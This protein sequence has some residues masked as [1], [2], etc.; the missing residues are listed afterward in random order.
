M[1]NKTVPRKLSSKKNNALLRTY[2]LLKRALL[3][4]STYKLKTKDGAVK[5]GNKKVAVLHFQYIVL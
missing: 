5:H 1:N 3:H 4:Y 2:A